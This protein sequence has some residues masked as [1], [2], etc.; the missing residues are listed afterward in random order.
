MKDLLW[1]K[2]TTSVVWDPCLVFIHRQQPGVAVVWVLLV[3][4]VDGCG[5]RGLV[6]WELSWESSHKWCPF[7]FMKHKQHHMVHAW[8]QDI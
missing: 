2:T 1:A 8:P 4:S 5:G 7:I 3:V 6:V